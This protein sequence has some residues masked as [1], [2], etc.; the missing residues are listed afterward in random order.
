MFEQSFTDRMSRLGTES[1]FAIMARANE[2]EKQGRSIIHCEIG[3]PDFKTPQFIM[4]AAYQAM[5][6]GYTGYGPTPGYPEVR[7]VISDYVNGY[8]HIHSVPESIVIVPGG[9]PIMFFCSLGNFLW[10]LRRRA[11]PFIL[12]NIYGEPGNRSRENCS[13]CKD[14]VN[15]D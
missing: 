10:K 12:R 5:L 2:L 6:D 15:M 4:D 1:A 13:I 7:K 11:F 3:Q 8:K 9:K 14:F